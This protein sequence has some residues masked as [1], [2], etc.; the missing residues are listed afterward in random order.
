[1]IPVFVGSDTVNEFNSEDGAVHMIERR[2]RLNIEAP[3]LLKKIVGVDLVYFIQKNTLNRRNRIL[4]IEA[5]NES[6]DTR[7]TINEYCRYFVSDCFTMIAIICR[8][9]MYL[10]MYN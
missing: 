9:S 2:C 10:C 5:Y 8:F 3:Y 4:E 7:I 1:M 6:F